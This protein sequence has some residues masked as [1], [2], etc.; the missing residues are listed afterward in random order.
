M[1]IKGIKLHYNFGWG[2]DENVFGCLCESFMLAADK[3]ENI[4]PTL[5]DVDFTN[6][7][8]MLSVYHELGV[9]VGDFKCLD[10]YIPESQ[11]I[12]ILNSKKDL[13]TTIPFKNVCWI[14]KVDDLKIPSPQKT[15]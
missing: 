13:R 9:S 3:I 10:K 7:K 12:E 4:S 2:I 5:G 11:L 1:K 14:F 8:N 15:A 6:F